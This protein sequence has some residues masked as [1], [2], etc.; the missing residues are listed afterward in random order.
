[1]HTYIIPNKSFDNSQIYFFRG[2]ADKARTKKNKT[3]EDIIKEISKL[4]VDV[5]NEMTNTNISE[6]R[7]NELVEELKKRGHRF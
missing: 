2:Y 5:V 4:D 1:M 3:K 6:A 7:Y